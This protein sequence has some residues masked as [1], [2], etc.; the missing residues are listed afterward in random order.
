MFTSDGDLGGPLGGAVQDAL[1]D[2][3]HLLAVEGLVDAEHIPD[4]VEHL[5]LVPLP[6]LHAVLHGHDDVLGAV[7]RTVLRA[8]LSR[9]WNTFTHSS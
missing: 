2:G 9:A 4:D 5:G 6:D 3:L 8:L 7:A 1:F